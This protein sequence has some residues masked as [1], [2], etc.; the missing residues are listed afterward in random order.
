MGQRVDGRI[1]R[2]GLA[3]A[4]AADVGLEAGVHV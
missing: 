2:E 1:L 4:V 3:P